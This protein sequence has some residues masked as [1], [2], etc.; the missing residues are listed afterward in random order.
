MPQKADTEVLMSF[1][2]PSTSAKGLLQIFS[3]ASGNWV[4]GYPGSGYFV[5]IPNNSSS[6]G[7]SKVSSGTITQL[8]SAAIGRATTTKQWVRFRIEGS[9][10]K[11]KVWTDGTQEPSAWEMQATDSSFSQPGVLQLRWA[12]SSTATDA[13]EVLLDD[14]TVTDL[15]S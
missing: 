1:T 11:L 4:S 14:L 3:R 5:E 8:S 6:V 15:G 2:T 7:L 13:R 10:L 9:T 12:R